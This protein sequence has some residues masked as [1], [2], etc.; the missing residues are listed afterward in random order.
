MSPLTSHPS[1][2]MCR[3]KFHHH[4]VECS[5]FK[6]SKQ[7]NLAGVQ[8]GPPDRVH[9]SSPLELPRVAVLEPDVRQLLLEAVRDALSEH[10]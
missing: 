2:H 6:C 3:M 1:Y 7:C 9:D 5:A 4:I 8:R 10:A